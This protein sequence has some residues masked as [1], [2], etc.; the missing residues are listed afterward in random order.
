MGG[1]SKQ[2]LANRQN[3]RLKRQKTTHCTTDDNIGSTQEIP[4]LTHGSDDGFS[5]NTYY[6]TDGDMDDGVDWDTDDDDID[7][8][9]HIAD[10][11]DGNLTTDDY[12]VILSILREGEKRA[13]ADTSTYARDATVQLY[14]SG[15][16]R[17]EGTICKKLRA[18]QNDNLERFKEKTRKGAL[19]ASL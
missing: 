3:G 1:V 18:L 5:K 12:E 8:H 11:D 16:T 15:Y 4:E 17:F 9:H 6:D 2:T 14:D 13:K 7:V 10:E 19:H